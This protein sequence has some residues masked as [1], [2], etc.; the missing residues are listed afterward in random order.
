MTRKK[1][2]NE[3]SAGLKLNAEL[4]KLFADQKKA[5]REIQE[6]VERSADP[7]V[8]E[9]LQKRKE[10]I[11]GQL[12]SVKEQIQKLRIPWRKRIANWFAGVTKAR[13]RQIMY[14]FFSCILYPTN[15]FVSLCQHSELDLGL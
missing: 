7:V 3:T 10:D 12:T 6:Q 9:S 1:T 2:L 4:K 11:E 5:V 8:V 15:S 14:A 13:D